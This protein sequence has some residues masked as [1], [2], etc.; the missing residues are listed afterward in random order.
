MKKLVFIS[1]LLALTLN[2]VYAQDNSPYGYYLDAARF[3]QTIP[4][5]TARIQGLGGTQ[6]ALGADVS[7]IFSN[8]AGLGLYNRSVFS[9][10]PSYTFNNTRADYFGQTREMDN[11][12]FAIDNIGI[13]FGGHKKNAGGWQGGSFGFG[14]NKINDFNNVTRYKGT[15]SE[16]SMI[17][18]FIE[19]AN[20]APDSQFP[21]LEQATDITTLAY[22]NYLIGP[23]NIIDPSFPEDEYFSDVV[24]FLRPSVQ[25]EEL[26]ETAG[27]QYQINASY[28]GNYGDFLYFGFGLGVTTVNYQSR[29]TYT[30]SQ[31]DYSAD[32]P[33]YDPISE[34]QVV[35]NLAIKGSGFNASFGLIVKPVSFLRFGASV[36]TPTMYNLTDTYD[37]TMSTQWNDFYYEDLIGGDTLLNNL[38][39]ESAIVNSGY[40]LRTPLKLAGG[41]ALFLGDVGFVTLDAEYL[42]YGQMR[43]SASDFSMDADNDYIKN[44]YSNSLNLRAG[45]EM[46]IDVI[47]FRAGYALINVPTESTID[48]NNANHRISAGFGLR[49]DTFFFDLALV[50]NRLNKLYSPYVLSDNSQPVVDA[51]VNSFSGIFTLGMN[52]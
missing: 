52:F 17:D 36:T 44:N 16:T 39:A 43:L 47:R 2:F 11:S 42:D 8:P 49:L 20:G 22:Y 35:E 28:G 32:D 34:M 40:Q 50:N 45:A 15:N 51:T 37:A 38:Y 25:Q 33:S 3:S 14:V 6:I 21:A 26:V 9:I 1:T 24:S 5:G 27:G 4:G 48:F 13:V 31:F 10:S 19:S 7:S 46:R 18:Y 30:E 29:K 41:A 23:W 12:H